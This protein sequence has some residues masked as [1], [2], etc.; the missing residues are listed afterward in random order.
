MNR[1]GSIGCVPRSDARGRA[2]VL[3]TD[4]PPLRASRSRTFVLPSCSWT[5]PRLATPREKRSLSQTVVATRMGTSASVV[6]KLEAGG[7]VKLSTLQRYCAPIGEKFAV[8]V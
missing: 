5:P 8:A 3:R 1:P 2:P 7:D 4:V 6:S